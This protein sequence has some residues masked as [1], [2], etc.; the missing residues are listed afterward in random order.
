MAIACS[1]GYCFGK[2]KAPVQTRMYARIS[3][4]KIADNGVEDTQRPC[5]CV[6]QAPRNLQEVD[7]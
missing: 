1:A 2:S 6:N 4:F 5:S 3:D 7:T